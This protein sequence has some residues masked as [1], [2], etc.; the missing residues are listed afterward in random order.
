MALMSDV[1]E[2]HLK[3]TTRKFRA[4]SALQNASKF[5]GPWPGRVRPGFSMERKERFF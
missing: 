5:A 3:C 1:Q 2:L 4:E